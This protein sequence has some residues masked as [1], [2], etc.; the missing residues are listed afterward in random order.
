MTT[1]GES[2]RRSEGFRILAKTFSYKT[3]KH[4]RC[5]ELGIY[6]D[7]LESCYWYNQMIYQYI[8][9][10]PNKAHKEYY[11]VIGSKIL[12]IIMRLI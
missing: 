7:L 3:T 12:I 10:Y 4:G 11:I 5:K 1:D 8:I 2:L 6:D 9:K